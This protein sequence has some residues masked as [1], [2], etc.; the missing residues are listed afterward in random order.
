MLRIALAG[1]HLLA[2]GIG[3]YAVLAR[4]SFLKE[5]AT[6]FTVRRVLRADLEW[7]LAA[8]LWVATGLWRWLAGTEKDPGYYIHNHV[9]LAKMGLFLLIFALEVW[10]IVTFTKWRAA[11]AKGAL[12]ESVANPI[13]AQRM[14]TISYVQAALVV[15]IVFHAVMMARGIGS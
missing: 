4:G 6:P 15:L 7:G 3:L 11:I 2:L 5:K 1:L 10:P 9:F 14:A 8:G 12:P 13:T